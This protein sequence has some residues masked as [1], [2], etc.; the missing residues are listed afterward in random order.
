VKPVAVLRV[1]KDAYG[2]LSAELIDHAVTLGSRSFSQ[3]APTSRLQAGAFSRM[4]V[5]GIFPKRAVLLQLVGTLL[6][7]QDDEWVGRGPSLLQ[8]WVD[9]EDWRTRRR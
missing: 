1:R 2:S 9:A 5:V 7:E 4:H 8:H 3:S 6:A